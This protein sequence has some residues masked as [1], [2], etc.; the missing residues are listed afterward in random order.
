M[1]HPANAGMRGAEAVGRGGGGAAHRSIAWETLPPRLLRTTSRPR[2]AARLLERPPLPQQRQ[3][4]PQ[5]HL[6]L[7]PA[8]VLPRRL[9]PAHPGDHALV[10]GLALQLADGGDDR[11]H[12]AP[13]RRRGVHLLAQ[14]EEVDAQAPELVEGDREV[15]RRAGEAVEP[16][17]S[18]QVKPAGAGVGHHPVEGGAAVLGAGDTIVDVL[19]G[20]PAPLSGDLAKLLELEPDV[21]TALESPYY[22]GGKL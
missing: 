13:H 17:H 22:L 10:G 6:H 14:R 4:R 19:G 11:E 7:R 3:R 9:R 1:V 12:R 8:A 5:V 20:G 18:D 15:L 2:D 21:P 16:P